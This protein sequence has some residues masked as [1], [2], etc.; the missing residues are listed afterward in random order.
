M[1]E[2]FK[3]LIRVRALLCILTAALSV[4]AAHAQQP[5][6]SPATSSDGATPTSV[7]SASS[8]GDQVI[9]KVGNL[10]VTQADFESMIR[11]LEAQQGPADLS[12]RAIADNYSSLL[13]LSQQAVANHLESSPD[14]VRQLALDRTQ[15][16]SN[17][18]FSKLKA[19][20]KPTEEEIKAYYSAHLD[21]YDVVQMRRLFIWTNDGSKDGHGLSQQDA[22]ALA[23]AVRRAYASGSDVK[24][25]MHDSVNDPNSVVYDA[26]PLT[27]QRGELPASMEQTAFALKEGGWT[28]LNDAPGTYVF[29]QVV[30]RNRKDLQEVSPQI[31]R[32]LQAQKLQGELD[33][34][35][36]KAGIWMDEQYFGAAPQKSVSGT[37]SQASG[38]SKSANKQERN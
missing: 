13:M 27:F 9:L 33:D 35:K 18:E 38:P 4:A 8:A 2:C 16:L 19:Q 25:L 3:K 11:A 15:I 6:S 10:Q 17:A 20:A 28:E 37:Q 23:A 26:Q 24:K 32:K 12:R 7:K 5:A 21:D 30:Q 34:L 36:K 14:V 31:E 29:L 1:F 22:T